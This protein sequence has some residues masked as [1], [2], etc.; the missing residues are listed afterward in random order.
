MIGR[1]G[2]LAFGGRWNSTSAI[3]IWVNGFSVFWLH[4][5][6]DI[7]CFDEFFHEY[8]ACKSDIVNIIPFLKLNSVI[9]SS[10]LVASWKDSQDLF[11]LESFFVISF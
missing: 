11:I 5:P 6:H 2:L 8:A 9:T 3:K 10:P 7:V 4:A 1:F